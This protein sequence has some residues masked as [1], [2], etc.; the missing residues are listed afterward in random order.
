MG[1]FDFAAD[2]GKKVFGI[3]DADA[4][5]QVQREIEVVNPGV[6]NLEVSMDGD[7]CTLTGECESAAAK[8]KTILVAGNTLGVGSVNADGLTA[9]EPITVEEDQ[10][11]TIESGDTLWGI[12]AK[13]MGNGAKYTEIFEANKEVIQDPDKIFPGQKIRIPKA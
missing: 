9:P 13:T 7:A 8:E 3:G 6:S 1:L 2:I 4:A 5:E 10:Y 11:Y 12:A